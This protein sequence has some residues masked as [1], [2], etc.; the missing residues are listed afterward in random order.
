M[1]NRLRVETFFSSFFWAIFGFCAVLG[2]V[3]NPHTSRQQVAALCTH[4]LEEHGGRDGH[5]VQLDLEGGVEGEVAVVVAAAPLGAV[6]PVVDVHV[7]RDRLLL[8]HRGRCRETA[9]NQREPRDQRKEGEKVGVEE[10]K[11]KKQ[12]DKGMR[13]SQDGGVSSTGR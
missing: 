2:V 9:E 4:H 1:K 5:P 6:A 3:A 7:Q 10:G 13:W 8:R 12:S 11:K